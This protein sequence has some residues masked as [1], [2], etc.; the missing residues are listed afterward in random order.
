MNQ[1]PRHIRQRFNLLTISHTDG[2]RNPLFASLL[3]R[4]IS[5]YLLSAEPTWF[6]NITAQLQT[7]NTRLIEKAFV[8]HLITANVNDYDNP[9]GKFEIKRQAKY[10]QVTATESGKF[11]SRYSCDLPA[12]QE[13][14]PS[15]YGDAMADVHGETH[16]SRTHT[17]YISSDF[18]RNKYNSKSLVLTVQTPPGY[19]DTTNGESNINNNSHNI[20]NVGSFMNIVLVIT[21]K[22]FSSLSDSA[23][24]QFNDTNQSIGDISSYTDQS[25]LQNTTSS[26][27][28]QQHSN[29]IQSAQF[30]YLQQHL[31]YHQKYIN[32]H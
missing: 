24:T 6:G 28:S 19:T 13:F 2:L 22:D 20:N 12:Y 1:I 15:R 4:S 14:N 7:I 32:H 29:E 26:L 16:Q 17:D 25:Q 5:D 21:E 10:K 11:L 23:S 27:M 9:T 31:G 3:R 8:S 18:Y 30:I